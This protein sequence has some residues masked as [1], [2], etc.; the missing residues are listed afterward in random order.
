MHDSME[1]NGIEGW[2]KTIWERGKKEMYLCKNMMEEWIF[3]T[4]VS[5]IGRR[6]EKGREGKQCHENGKIGRNEARPLPVNGK[7]TAR[8]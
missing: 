4:L 3:E 7:A 8:L 1:W 2:L 5:I 6:E